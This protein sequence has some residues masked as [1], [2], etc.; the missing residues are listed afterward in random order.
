[1]LFFVAAVFKISVIRI[2]GIG[3][4]IEIIGKIKHSVR[5]GHQKQEIKSRNKPIYFLFS[6]FIA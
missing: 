6:L 5:K 3:L 4:H 2:S 1:M